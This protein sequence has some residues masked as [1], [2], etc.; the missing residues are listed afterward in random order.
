MMKGKEKKQGRG[1]KGLPWTVRAITWLLV[2]EAAFLLAARLFWNEL[3]LGPQQLW[4]NQIFGLSLALLAILAAFSALGFVIVRPAAW[5]LAM[6]TQ[7]LILA[8]LLFAYFRYRPE[9]PIFYIL[10]LYGVILVFYLNYA[11]V[12]LIFRQQEGESDG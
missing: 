3:L 5:L 9:N 6:L 10:L 2:G 8:F 1:L 12:P 7:G 4:V 11:E